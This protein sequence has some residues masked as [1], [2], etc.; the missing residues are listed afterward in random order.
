MKKSKIVLTLF[1]AASISSCKNHKKSS[2]K[3]LNDWNDDNNSA[4]ISTNGGN[5]YSHALNNT[6]FWLYYMLLSNN[7]GGYYY[8]TGSMYQ[9][10]NRSQGISSSYSG[11]SVRQ[12][13][14]GTMRGGFGSSARSFGS[15]HSIGG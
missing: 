8:G 12:G 10:H 5:G 4:Y 7:R 11:R 13:S 1:L 2:H 15:S 9:N 6:T 14:S 3:S